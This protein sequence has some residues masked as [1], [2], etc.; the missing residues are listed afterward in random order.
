MPALLDTAVLVYC[1][2]PRVPAKRRTAMRLVRDGLQR[3]DLRVPHQALVEFYAVVTR[4]SAGRALMTAEEAARE[5]EEMLLGFEVL[6]PSA[7]VVREALRGRAAYGLSWFNAH[8]WAYAEHYGCEMLYSEDFQHGRVYGGVRVL[9][10][11][12]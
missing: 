9:N 12:T 7:A 6:F 2:D 8:L 5:V 11:F 1:H 4:V 10:P 3:N